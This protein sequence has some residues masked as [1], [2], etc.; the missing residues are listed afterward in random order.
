[1]ARTLRSDGQITLC[2]AIIAARKNAG[3]RQQDLAY[4]LRCQQSFVARIESG[5]RRIDVVEFLVLTRAIGC[6][7]YVILAMVEAALEPNHRI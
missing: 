1:M 3:L 6:D 4:R 2:R 5:Q 7:P